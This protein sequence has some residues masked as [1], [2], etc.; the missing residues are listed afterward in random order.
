LYAALP[1]LILKLA[2]WVSFPDLGGV[3]PARAD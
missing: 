3:T 1:R 2:C